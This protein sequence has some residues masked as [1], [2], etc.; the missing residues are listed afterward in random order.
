MKIEKTA[1]YANSKGKLIFLQLEP[2]FM[3]INEATSKYEIKTKKQYCKKKIY[4]FSQLSISELSY[5]VYV[6][7]MVSHVIKCLWRA[8]FCFTRLG[9][10]F[11]IQGYVFTNLEYLLAL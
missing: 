1:N 4:S 5:L 3:A 7:D 11:E 8:M 10:V 6:S 2:E 9:Y